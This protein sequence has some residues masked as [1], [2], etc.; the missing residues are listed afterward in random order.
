MRPFVRPAV[1]VGTKA[2][3]PKFGKCEALVTR[4]LAVT[5]PDYDWVGAG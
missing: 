2:V 4:P 1:E 3:H 5:P